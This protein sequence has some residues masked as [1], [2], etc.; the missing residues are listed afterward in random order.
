MV[1][2]LN[3]GSINIDHV[4][5]VPQFVRPGETLSSNAYQRFAGGK[6]LNQSIALAHAGMVVF[7][8]GKINQNDTW[9]VDLLKQHGVDTTCLELGEEASGHALISVN[10]EGENSILLF[11]GANQSISIDQIEQVV[12]SFD[13]SDVLLLQNEINA[14]PRLMKQARDKGMQIVFNPSPINPAVMAYPLELVDLFI[15]NEIEAGD[16]AG[17]TDPVLAIQSLHQQFPQALIV[18]TLGSAGV[19]C[20]SPGGE[21]YF[22]PAESVT[23]VDTTAAGDTFTGF[24][25]AEYL[26]HGDIRQALAIACRAAAICVTRPGAADSIPYLHELENHP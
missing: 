13:T 21:Q 18:M 16:L 7:H 24:F 2:V 25:L 15:L 20:I 6:G 11:G 9:L 4:Y 14:V 26:Q 12:S 5:Q 22:Q 23:P 10:P 3:F 1:K 8:A 17:E 19:R